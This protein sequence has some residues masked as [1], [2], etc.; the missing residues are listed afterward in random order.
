MFY[1]FVPFSRCCFS[2]GLLIWKM[3]YSH[4][5][6]RGKDDKSEDSGKE[7]LI[8]GGFPVQPSSCSVFRNHSLFSDSEI[9]FAEKELRNGRFFHLSIQFLETNVFL[10]QK[11]FFVSQCVLLWG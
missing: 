1:D 8:T 9:S 2:F 5:S 7:E 10:W 11:K 4:I 6:R 3:H